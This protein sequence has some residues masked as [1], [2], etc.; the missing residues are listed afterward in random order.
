MF[1]SQ[2]GNAFKRDATGL[3]KISEKSESYPGKVTHKQALL[4]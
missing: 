2:I 3:I 4:A 1:N